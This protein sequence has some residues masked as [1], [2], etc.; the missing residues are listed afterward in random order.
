VVPLVGVLRERAQVGLV[1]ETYDLAAREGVSRYTVTVTLSRE[2]AR[3]RG[4]VDEL[5]ATVVGALAST[6]GVR[7]GRDAL[8][9]TYDR[10]AAAA[11]RVA[12]QLTLDLRD[13]PAGTYRLMIEVRDRVTGRATAR[14]TA[15]TIA[16]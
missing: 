1:W 16:D 15:L 8:T 7:R 12:D 11:P 4:T 6:A 2:Q 3:R 10:E 13:I 14:E 5:S 9:I